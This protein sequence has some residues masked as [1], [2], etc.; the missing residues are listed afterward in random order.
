MTVGDRVGTGAAGGAGRRGTRTA[1]AVLAAVAACACATPG[2]A[3]E[4]GPVLFEDGFDGPGLDT[5][6]WG[7][8]HW[9]D[10]GGCTIA[11]NGELEWYL[12]GQVEVG[13]GTL[14]LTADHAPTTGA[15]GERYPFRSGMVSTGP[16]AYTGSGA[17][18]AFTYGTV[19]ARV[20][21]PEGA[22]L[23][24]ALWLLPASR[25]ARPEIDLLEV[26]GDAPR[27]LLVHLHPEDPARPAVGES[28]RLPG[29]ADFADWRD[30]RLEWEPGELRWYV[31]GALVWTRTG[32]DVPDEPMYL[33]ANLAVGGVLPGPPDAATAFPAVFELDHVRVRAGAE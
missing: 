23:W 14:R 20:R 26:V 24:S 25:E 4:P 11:T 27:D 21:V 6:A 15:D 9:W 30:V 8:C 16:P 7:T 22:G 1:L 29:G 13:G 28:V 5:A 12:P 32:A 19:E 3:R 18:F 10:D 31:D 33:V 17:R 2:A